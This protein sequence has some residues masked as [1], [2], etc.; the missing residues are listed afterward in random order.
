MSPQLNPA[1]LQH[2]IENGEKLVAAKK[3]E[4]Q[5]YKRLQEHLPAFASLLRGIGEPSEP[6]LNSL[7]ELQYAAFSLLDV[8]IS[9]AEVELEELEMQ[10]KAYKFMQKQSE[11]RIQV[12][13]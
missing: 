3:L 5:A 13:R 10:V 11:S 6:V 1:Q 8:K 2:A 9:R 12:P 7:G 4:I